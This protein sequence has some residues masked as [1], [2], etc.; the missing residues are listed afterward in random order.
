V[1]K[2]DAAE[3]RG[4]PIKERLTHS[5]VKGLSEVSLILFIEVV[6]ITVSVVIVVVGTWE[7]AI[8]WRGKPI[9]E[10]LTY[11]LVKGLSEVSLYVVFMDVRERPLKT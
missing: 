11:S 6:M 8:E 10:L 1:V 9:K 4:K 2:K 5:L 3:W 7:P